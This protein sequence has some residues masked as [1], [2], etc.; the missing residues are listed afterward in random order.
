[1]GRMIPKAEQKTKRISI[2]FTPATDKAIRK[3]ARQKGLQV[4]EFVRRACLD[5]AGLSVEGK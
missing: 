4:S 2:C 3:A 5:Y 1:M